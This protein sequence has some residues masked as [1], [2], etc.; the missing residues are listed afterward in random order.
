[1]PKRSLGTRRIEPADRGAVE[2]WDT[3]PCAV[4]CPRTQAP[5]G[6]ATPRSSASPRRHVEQAEIEAELRGNACPSGAWARGRAESVDCKSSPLSP[7]GR[8]AGGE[9]YPP[10]SPG[11]VRQIRGL[12]PSLSR[13]IRLRVRAVHGKQAR[14]R[15]ANLASNPR[16]L[17]KSI[18]PG[19]PRLRDRCRRV[20]DS[21]Y[22]LSIGRSV[23]RP[24]A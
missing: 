24:F 14:A 12:W 3:L 2:S 15:G 23:A 7:C 4:G 8:G 19:R 16:F 17:K 1:V 21:L 18:T 20:L 22:I 6:P 13:L 9:G 5:L 11:I 10:C